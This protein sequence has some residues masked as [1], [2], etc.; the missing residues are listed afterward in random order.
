MRTRG[1]KGTEE[2]GH[3]IEERDDNVS[4][5]LNSQTKDYTVKSQTNIRRLTPNECSR[6]QGFSWKKEDGSWDDSWNDIGISDTQRYKQF[7]NAVSVPV[8]KAVME[9]IYGKEIC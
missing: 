1:D 9:R 4:N 6:L 5:A 2:R 8:V 7:G 3:R